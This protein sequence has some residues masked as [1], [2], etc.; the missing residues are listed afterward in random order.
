MAKKLNL[1]F[2]LSAFEQN[3]L[4]KSPN[5]SCANQEVG[6]IQS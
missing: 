4:L 3:L 5:P 2:Q 1:V 6:S